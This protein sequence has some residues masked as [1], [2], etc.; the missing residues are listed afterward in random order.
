MMRL[1]DFITL[2][3]SSGV[4]YINIYPISDYPRKLRILKIPYKEGYSPAKWRKRIGDSVFYY[5]K[6]VGDNF[7]EIDINNPIFGQIFRRYLLDTLSENITKPWQ[8]KE[9][10]ST[11]NIVKE[12]SENYG[13]SDKIKLQYELI[14]GVHHWQNTNFGLIVD[15]KINVFDRATTERISYTEIGNKYGEDVRKS[16]W[17]L[18]KF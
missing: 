11:L 6:D 5:G 4:L 3:R 1:D 12:I 8:I 15:L 9:L 14:T 2:K 7:E 17:R 16:I 18:I 13:Y 10:K